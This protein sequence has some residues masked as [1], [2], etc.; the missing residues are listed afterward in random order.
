M[1]ELEILYACHIKPFLSP[2]WGKLPTPRDPAE[3]LRK[4]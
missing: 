1:N 2:P 3:D 4:Q